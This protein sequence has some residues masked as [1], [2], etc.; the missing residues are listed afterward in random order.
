M[1]GKRL[2][3]ISMICTLILASCA[4]S[5]ATSM[6]SDSYKSLNGVTSAEMPSIAPVATMSVSSADT[7]SSGG[8]VASTTETIKQMVIQNASLTILVDDPSQSLSDVMKLA[9]DMGGFTVNS[10]RYQSY[11]ASGDEQVPEASVT[12]RVPSA[13]LND[14]LDQIKAM[15]GDAKKY[16]LNESV[17]GEDV[18]QQYTD[19]QS[20]LRNLEEAE[21]ELSK[22]YDKATKTDDVLAIY[23][24]KVQV[25]EQIEVLKGQIQ[26]YEQASTN[27]A[28]TVQIDAKATIQPITVAG[29][30][31]SGV[32]RDAIQALLDFLKGL[33]NFLIWFGLLILPILIILGVPLFFL[34][35]WLTRRSRAAK[36]KSGQLP[37]LPNDNK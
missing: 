3:L 5:A 14:A 9:S 26:Y 31:P 4:Q 29:W 32:A 35:R 1:K 36:A 8:T 23:N 34:I 33:V 22:L 28:I 24:Q 25:T 2:F 6:P 18:T 7:V 27:S 12:I 30:Q 13:K 20:R 37:P 19:T 16:V 17:T 11:T 15:T 10:S 21:V